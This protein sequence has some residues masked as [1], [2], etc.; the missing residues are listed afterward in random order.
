MTNTISIWLAVLIL[1]FFALDYF[2]LDLNA[3][4]FLARKFLQFMEYIAFWR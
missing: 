3:P 4:I 2:L 1:G